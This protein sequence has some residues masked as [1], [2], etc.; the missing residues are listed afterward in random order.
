MDKVT[1]YYVCQCAFLSVVIVTHTRTRSLAAA[2]EARSV[3]TYRTSSAFSIDEMIQLWRCGSVAAADGRQKSRTAN[4]RTHKTRGPLIQLF[5][6]DRQ[7]GIEFR[8]PQ[9]VE[10]LE[11]HLNKKKKRD[12][13]RGRR[14]RSWAG[15]NNMRKD[16]PSSVIIVTPH[17]YIRISWIT[18]A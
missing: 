18:Y 6:E 5:W 10:C 14:R 15:K 2:A 9:L 1:V 12:L 11:C 7:K 8:L 17:M 4:G 3:T 13:D 16:Y